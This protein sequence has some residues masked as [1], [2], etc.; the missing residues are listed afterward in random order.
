[1]FV[2][3]LVEALLCRSTGVTTAQVDAF[4]MVHQQDGEPG[5]HP[6]TPYRWQQM[7][8]QE[9]ERALGNCASTGRSIWEDRHGAVS[10]AIPSWMSIRNRKSNLAGKKTM[11]EGL[12]RVQFHT[13][14]G[15]GAGVVFLQAGKL[16]GGDSRNFYV[17]TY[18]QS[19]N[20]VT[21][22]VTTD[23][24]TEIPGLASV[25]GNRSRAH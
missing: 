21:A 13:Q 15:T 23:K 1:M 2:H 20:H 19:G 3:E 4:D 5:E 18:A 24:H 25:F 8:A 6:C 10:I 14:L 11:R 12:Y 16:R 9:A 22:E 17:R 7:A